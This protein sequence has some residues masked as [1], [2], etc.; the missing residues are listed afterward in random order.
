MQF[1]THTDCEQYIALFSV[2]TKPV[3]GIIRTGSFYLSAARHLPPPHWLFFLKM[4]HHRMKIHLVNPNTTASMTATAVDAAR[5]VANSNTEI[6]SSQP[7]LS[8]IHI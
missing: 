5:A 2:T 4:G 6:I 1:L 3:I 7:D 8:L